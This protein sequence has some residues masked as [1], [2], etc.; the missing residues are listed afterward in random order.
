[1]PSVVLIVFALSCGTVHE[2]EKGSHENPP[3]KNQLPD[4]FRNGTIFGG[5]SVDSKIGGNSLESFARASR[6]GEQNIEA[7]FM[8]TKDAIL[9]SAHHNELSGDCPKVSTSTWKRL[10]SC[11]LSGNRHVARLEDLLRLPFKEFYIDLKDTLGDR[12]AAAVRKAA[13]VI[14]K[15]NHKGRAVVMVYNASA[16][17]VQLIEHHDLRSGMKGYPPTQ[18]ALENL[19]DTAAR[20]RMEL[21]CVPLVKQAFNSVT[22]HIIDYAARQGVWVLGWTS[23]KAPP[24]QERAKQLARSGMGGLLTR[25]YWRVDREVKPAWKKWQKR[26]SK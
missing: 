7:D 11:L 20:H 16:E 9:V 6:A 10:K 13:V 23:K 21:V 1:V 5:A 15:A 4:Q 8:L 18:A 2:K 17:I 14:H 3:E 19:I 22:P 25:Y 26:G 12:G 24:I